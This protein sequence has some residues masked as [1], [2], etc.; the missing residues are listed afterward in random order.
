MLFCGNPLLKNRKVLGLAL[1]FAAYNY[2]FYLL[3]TWLPS[4]VTGAFH[5]DL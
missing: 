3:L 4:Y 5:L 2:C 1:G